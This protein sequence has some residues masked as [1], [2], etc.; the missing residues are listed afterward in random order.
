M[1]MLDGYFRMGGFAGGV[2]GLGE[3]LCVIN[4]NVNA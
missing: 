2:E 1:D 3:G 4:T